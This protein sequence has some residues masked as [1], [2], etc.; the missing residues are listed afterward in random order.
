[1]Q[2]W[3]VITDWEVC[4]VLF[5]TIVPAAIPASSAFNIP[6]LRQPSQDPYVVALELP[7]SNMDRRPKNVIPAGDCLVLGS[8]RGF[9]NSSLR[10]VNDILIS[11]R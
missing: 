1:M 9:S 11:A 8:L 4:L 6:S 10:S 7:E 3:A 5:R 2:F